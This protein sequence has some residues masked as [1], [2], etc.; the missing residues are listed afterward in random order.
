MQMNLAFD[1]LETPSKD[2]LTV[3]E[4]EVEFLRV[5]LIKNIRPTS[6]GCLK[7]IVID[8]LLPSAPLSNQFDTL[9]CRCT[10]TLSLTSFQSTQTDGSEAM[11][12]SVAI[13]GPASTFSRRSP[14]NE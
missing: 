2:K 14:M 13:I 4:M 3:L 5:N 8:N 6:A 11:R 1:L 10:E 7:D 12:E 9:Q